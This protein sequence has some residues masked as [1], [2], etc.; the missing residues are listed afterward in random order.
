V[1]AADVALGILFGLSLA[2]PP[3]PVNALMVLESAG[4]GNRRGTLVG[5]G[6]MTA[7][8][9]FFAL[10]DLLGS[11]LEPG[12]IGRIALYLL[13]MAVLLAFALRAL[14][15]RRE[16]PSPGSSGDTAAP[17]PRPYLKGLAM[18]LTNPFQILWWLTVGLSIIVLF[19]LSFVGGF[20]LGIL[21]WILLFPLAIAVA[22]RRFR[23][24]YRWIVYASVA[25]ILAFA[26]WSLFEAAS[27]A[28]GG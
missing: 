26:G 13:G 4:G 14:R 18:G 20:F 15:T 12:R 7:D 25:T 21:A 5:A 2:A 22:Q 16:L 17:D 24:L 11:G 19:G 10:T 9:I 1:A 28:V 6:A 27:L 8:A 23:S 3:G